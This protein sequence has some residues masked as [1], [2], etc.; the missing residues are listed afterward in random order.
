[1]RGSRQDRKRLIGTAIALTVLGALATAWP[2]G[3]LSQAQTE[4]DPAAC[5]VEPRDAAWLE[6]L[7]AP[8]AP[9]EATP[10]PIQASPVPADAL[11]T[12]E[13]AGPDILFAINETLRELV[14][15][16]NAGDEWR[17]LA[18]LT[19]EP[20][21]RAVLTI[22]GAAFVQEPHPPAS[23]TPLSPEMRVPFFSIR[24]PRIL[25]D[26]RVGAIVSNDALPDESSFF[27]FEEQDGRWLIDDAYAT[28]AGGAAGP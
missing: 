18:L 5:Q 17:A 14:A 20:T 4:P 12:G 11:P 6:A 8:P 23:P 25:P 22:F 21:P 7:F 19:D 26:G 16:V 27:I 24:D 28:E 10:A 1:M 15:C 2:G 13:P 9:G 3:V